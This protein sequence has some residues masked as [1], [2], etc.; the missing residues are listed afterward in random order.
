MSDAIF[1]TTLSCGLPLVAER[2]PGV[3][4][5]AVCW[6]LPVGCG[7]DRS[8][9]EG[10]STMLSEMVFRGAGSLD[11]RAQAD[12]LDHLG[13]ARG[14]DVGGH[15]LRFSA[16]MLADRLEPAWPLFVDIVRSP[17]LDAAAMEP[18]RELSLQALAGLAD[19]PQEK[20]A[21]VLSDRHNDLPL[22]R[23]GMGTEAGLTAITREDLQSAWRANVN[24]QSSILAVAGAIDPDAIAARLEKLL[25]GWNG[26]TPALKTSP[27][28]T[29]GTYH[30]V[31]DDSAS[32]VHIFLAHEAPR[33][34]HPHSLMERVALA[35]LS[36]GTS[37][38]LFTEVREKRGL[39]Y[40][41]SAGYSAERDHGRVT[42]YVGT[43]PDKAQESLDVFRAELSRIQTPQGAVTANEFNRAVVR[44][45]TSLVFSG[46]STGSRAGALASDMHRI[47]RPRSLAELAAAVDRLTLTDLNDYLRTRQT[48]PMTIVTLGPKPLEVS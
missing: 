41:V 13:L 34:A 17:T 27:S 3:R 5:V 6:L 15:Y 18:V 24:P 21:L 19:E 4:S 45:K 31:Q 47:G 48:G 23:T 30:H 46:E 38:R 8:D 25:S 32:Q 16:T 10:V 7:Y 20:A 43:T 33:E 12:A 36:G 28:P 40:S 35:I 1:S 2:V 14:A 11:S 9:R 29:R 37:A 44:F 42:G 39:C 26:A 22:N